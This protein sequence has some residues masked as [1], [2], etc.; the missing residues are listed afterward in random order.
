MSFYDNRHYDLTLALLPFAL[1]GLIFQPFIFV[2]LTG[3][4][5]AANRGG[6]WPAGG[7]YIISLSAYLGLVA[8]TKYPESDLA[9]YLDSFELAI[10][11]SYAEFLYIHPKEPIFYSYV[12]LLG[13][14][15]ELTGGHFVF[16]TVAGSYFLILSSV[17][18]VS[19]SLDLGASYAIVPILMAAWWGLMFSNA[20]H[21]MRQFVAASL[22]L[23]AWSFAAERPKLKYLILAAAS[24]CHT[25]AAVFILLDVV[26]SFVRN[27][28]RP[29][30]WPTVVF[31]LLVLALARV[32]AEILHAL[33]SSLGLSFLTYGLARLGAAQFFELPPLGAGP[34]AATIAIGLCSALLYPHP[35]FVS[36][37]KPESTSRILAATVFLAVIVIISH[38]LGYS[39]ISV[40]F[41]VYIYVFSP[42]ALVAFLRRLAPSKPVIPVFLAVILPFHFV[43]QL[44]SGV[45]AYA[46]TDTL[47][48]A[49]SW[50]I[51]GNV[52]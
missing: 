3:I 11:F 24:F 28:R 12:Y 41:L 42:I 14:V 4:I 51:F 8:T 44:N 5:L 33:A 43:Y 46:P 36:G 48:L 6:V 22:V 35:R 31:S 37:T 10:S 32:G 9:N 25:S 16:I 19:R 34:I 20:P 39:E 47:M 2:T 21:L 27:S 45:W 15:G 52:P 50:E 23:I 40:R 18:R 1:V 49:P 26:Q 7:V 38:L 29:G 30:L 17:L 13:N